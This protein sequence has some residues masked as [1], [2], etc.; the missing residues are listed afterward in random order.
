MS[1]SF[2]SEASFVPRNANVKQ[3]KFKA[4][5]KVRGGTKNSVMQFLDVG[6]DGFDFSDDNFDSDN[7]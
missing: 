7:A 4:N 1:K 2:K 3:V 6:E 5:K